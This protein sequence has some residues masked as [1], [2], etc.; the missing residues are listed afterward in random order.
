MAD[1]TGCVSAGWTPWAIIAKDTEV[2]VAS[3]VEIAHW[4]SMNA[5]PWRSDGTKSKAKSPFDRRVSEST[6][7]LTA[8][9]KGSGSGVEPML[10]RH[11]AIKIQ[12]KAPNAWRQGSP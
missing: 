4:S 7:T 8:R 12:D 11:A 10:S 1:A 5:C 9:F 2:G 3:V 6:T